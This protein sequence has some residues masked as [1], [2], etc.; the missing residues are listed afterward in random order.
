MTIDG[1]AEVGTSLPIVPAIVLLK[2]EDISKHT[3][4]VSNGDV[5]GFHSVF[6][7]MKWKGNV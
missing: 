5:V 7:Q 4:S 3:N 1:G 2:K 6:I